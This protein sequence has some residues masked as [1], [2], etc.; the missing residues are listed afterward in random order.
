MK[1]SVRYFFG[2]N[3][4]EN[5][6][7]NNAAVDEGFQKGKTQTQGPGVVLEGERADDV[8]SASV[9]VL[10]SWQHVARKRVPHFGAGR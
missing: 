9:C 4:E 3:K 7:L 8:R 6:A 5:E 1:A 10:V 2:L